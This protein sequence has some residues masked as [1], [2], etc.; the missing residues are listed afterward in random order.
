M[1]RSFV[2][3]VAFCSALVIGCSKSNEPLK[4]ETKA[5]DAL[6]YVDGG[7][8]GKVGDLKTFH[9]KTGEHDLELRD[10]SGHTYYQEH[11]NVLAGKTLDLNPN[12]PVPNANQPEPAP[13]PNNVAPAAGPTS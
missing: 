8:A 9:L 13:A 6:V 5:K 1:K 3:Q 11:V 7:Y 12:A 10:P 4:F 2:V